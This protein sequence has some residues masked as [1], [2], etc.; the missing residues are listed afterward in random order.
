M[1]P[2]NRPLRSLLCLP[3]QL[4]RIYRIVDNPIPF[5]TAGLTRKLTSGYVHARYA[6]L[7]LAPLQ[8]SGGAPLRAAPRLRMLLLHRRCQCVPG[9][10][11]SL[12]PRQVH[13][14]PHLLASLDAAVP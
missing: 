9:A 11:C 7:L 6:G 8:L 12:A 2:H 14:P 5:A 10:S 3:V 13:P 1:P 4:I